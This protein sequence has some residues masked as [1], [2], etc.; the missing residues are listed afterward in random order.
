[1]KKIILSII[2][3]GII[4]VPTKSFALD[5]DVLLKQIEELF[6]IVYQLQA[7]L[8]ELQQKQ[9]VIQGEVKEEDSEERNKIKEE[10][11]K[12]AWLKYSNDFTTEELRTLWKDALEKESE[13]ERNKIKEE[14]EELERIK[15][16][17]LE[18]KFNY[19]QDGNKKYNWNYK[20]SSGS[21][22]IFSSEI[23]AFREFYDIVLEIDIKTQGREEC[24][25]NS[26]QGWFFTWDEN[27]KECKRNLQSG[28]YLDRCGN[29]LKGTPPK[30]NKYSGNYGGI[31]ACP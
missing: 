4:L 5:R 18:K 25:K 7:Q 10:L 11:N 9:I 17:L 23:E 30:Q 24:L 20:G 27:K 22:F 26:S 16:I 21:N 3:T 8:L 28:Y 19:S 29:P 31:Y 13:E 6:K 1:M 15:K 12:R 14:K 2:I